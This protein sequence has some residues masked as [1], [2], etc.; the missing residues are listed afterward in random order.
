MKWIVLS[1]AVIMGMGTA[2]LWYTFAHTPP[3]DPRADLRFSNTQEWDPEL[4]ATLPDQDVEV[5][6]RTDAYLA[7]IILPPPPQ[8]LSTTTATELAELHRF[9]DNERTAAQADIEA[10]VYAAN[11]R[12]GEYMYSHNDKPLTTE[13]LVRAREELVP[14]LLEEKRRFDRVRPSYLDP[15][16]TTAIPVPGHPAYPSGHATETWLTALILSALDPAHA[17]V[18]KADS[19]RIAHNREIA[20]VHYPSDGVAGRLLAE[21][22]YALFFE[23]AA[24]HAMLEKARAEW[25]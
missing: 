14:V 23:N 6:T 18:Y 25:R 13:L 3:H 2:G 1:I 20:G 22:F 8:N 4:Y 7:R 24:A 19:L 11:L 17:D 10:E 21:Q 15:T 16:L 12:F 5:A 9:A